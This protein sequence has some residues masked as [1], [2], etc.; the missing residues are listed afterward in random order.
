MNKIKRNESELTKLFMEC[1]SNEEIYKTLISLGE[2]TPSLPDDK[3]TEENRVHGCQSQL[4]ITHSGSK[5]EIYFEV[6]SDALISKGL[7]TLLTRIYNGSSA[8]EILQTPLSL[9]KQI[10][11]LS[12]ISPTRLTGLDELEKRMK[13]IALNYLM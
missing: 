12:I 11:L 6:D 9:F 2:T 1:S 4:Y 10:H 8:E 3:K 13:Q 5:E 7:A